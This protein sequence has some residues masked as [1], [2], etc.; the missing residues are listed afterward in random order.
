M[1]RALCTLSLLAVACSH[2][3]TPTRPSS[4][5]VAAG[6]ELSGQWRG[7]FEITACSGARADCLGRTTAEFMLTFVPVGA[8]LEGVLVLLDNE[9]TTV[10]VSGVPTADGNYAF[11]AAGYDQ[12]SQGTYPVR[13]VV[14]S[15]A[16]RTDAAGGLVGSMTYTNETFRAF[17][18][19]VAFRS[20]V[21]QPEAEH[22]GYF[23]GAWKG[24]YRTLSCSGDC[25]V[26][27]GGYNF[28]TGGYLEM[29]FSEAGGQVVG[30]VL[31]L[32]VTGATQSDA[33]SATGPALTAN[34][35]S[36]C[37]DCEGVCQSA[38]Q[39]VSARVDKLGRMSGTFE[40]SWKG[41]TGNEHFRQTGL[42]EMVG[43]T[44]RW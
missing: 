36:T 21:R 7:L 16:C 25:R 26:G 40:Y 31:S 30:T 15:I 10:N 13:T 1:K 27:G 3:P 2:S 12:P 4:T 11:T 19:T 24:Y 9:R 44:R 17:T 37:W 32:P 43:V 35:C 14:S 28:P 33:L 42:V 20:A 5:A 6:P 38:V 23:D 8:G 34:A 39:N 18:R 22:P 29:A 41:W